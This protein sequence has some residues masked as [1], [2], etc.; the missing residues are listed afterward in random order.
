MERKRELSAS[1]SENEPLYYSTV[2]ASQVVLS[3]EQL[4]NWDASA[5]AWLRAADRV[6][7]V[8][9]KQLML[10]I[11]NIRIPVNNKMHVYESVL[12]AWKTAMVTME[13]LVSGMPQSVQNG[14]ILLGLSAWHLY[15]D[16][17]VL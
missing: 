7:V 9:Q 6:M 1:F 10:I 15:P 13:K 16:M 8:E 2:A 14:E 11:D 17:L 5:R 4:A 12:Q 3:R